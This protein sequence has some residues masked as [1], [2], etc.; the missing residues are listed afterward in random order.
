VK[1]PSV[2]GHRGARAVLPENTLPAFEFAIRAGVDAI[3]LDVLATADDVLVVTHDPLINEE[4]CSNGPAGK[5]VRALTFDELVRCDCGSRPNPNFPLQWP[6][7]GARIP[8]LDEVLDLWRLGNFLFN[9][10]VKSFPAQEF[11]APPADLARLLVD[12]LAA[13]RLF[14]RVLV[15]SFDFRVLAEVHHLNS[16]LPLAALWEGPERDP[17]D[18][19]LQARADAV[20]LLHTLIQPEDVARAHGA[21]L[22][23]LAW[24]ANDE[25]A[26]YRL[27]AAGVDAIIT[28]DPAALIDFLRA[29]AHI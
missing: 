7:P 28:D 19:A 8:S 15:Q 12:R 6:V 24:T 18:I 25:A 2:H 14:H 5:A 11:S 9:I 27:V 1:L 23:V 17:L 21:G 26:W 10:E 20:S 29:L 13:H 16:D 22:Q 4:L 3:E